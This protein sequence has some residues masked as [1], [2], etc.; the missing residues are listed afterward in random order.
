MA[1]KRVQQRAPNRKWV[2]P[3][4]GV[5]QLVN[6]ADMQATPEAKDE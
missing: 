5:Q 6:D 1:W 3:L 2:K 4:G